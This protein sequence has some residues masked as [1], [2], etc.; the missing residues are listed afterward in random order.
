MMVEKEIILKDAHIDNEAN[1]NRYMSRVN[2][3]AAIFA[4]VLLVMYLTK[5]FTIPDYFLPVVYILFSVSAVVLAIPFFLAKTNLIRKRW[6]KY[7]ILFSLLAVIMAVNIVVPKHGL[8][9]WPFAIFIANHY[10]STKLGTIVYV[11]TMLAMLICMYLGMFFGEYDEN[12]LGSGIISGGQIILPDT[13]EE[14][15]KMLHELKLNGDNRYVKVLIFYYAPRAAAITLF[16][17]VSNILN[18]R[19][20]NLVSDEMRI[21]NEQEKSKTELEVAKGI[22][23]NTLPEE[24]TASKEVE[25]IGELKA[26]K[27][28]GGDFYDYL[29]IDENHVAIIIGDVSGKGVPAAMFMMKTITSF[30]D[31]ATANKTPSQILKEVNSSIHRG[32]VSNMFVTCF[33]AILDKRD[34]KLIYANAG[35]NKPVVGH[36]RAYRFLD[37]QSGF[38][39]GGFKDAFI[40]DEEIVLQPEDCITLYTDGITEARNNNKEFFGEA[41]LLNTF[42]KTDYTSIV[43]IHRGLKE[44]VANFVLNAP[45]SDDITFVTLKYRGSSYSNVEKV[46][47]A[48]NKN[49]A[50]MLA[51]INEFGESHGFPKPFLNKLAIVG[52]EIISNIV[53]HGYQNNGGEILIRLSFNDETKDFVLTVIDEAVEFNQLDVEDKAYEKDS[54]IEK[55]GG[56]GILIVKTIMDEYAYDH[57]NGKNILV[58]KKKL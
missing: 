37:C 51:Y 12:L 8:L 5:I 47:D 32:N 4:V 56:L 13:F 14:R 57:I 23:L 58:L 50:D 25:I 19:A 17:I 54:K 55:V 15:L 3:V 10:Y 45:Q 30:R 28:V 53:H 52:D 31:F 43:E 38:L 11:S 9:L 35:H 6:Y 39:L 24:F 42:N 16:Y 40:T 44:E 20:Y 7:F 34:G 46:F 1:A 36:N 21:Q 27:E 41:R 29:D 18:R 22:Q 48:K 26:A 2:A 49:I 33:L